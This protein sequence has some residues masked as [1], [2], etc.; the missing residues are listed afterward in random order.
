MSMLKNK[1]GLI[2]GIANEHSIAYGCAK[3]LRADGAE[4]AATYLNEEEEPYVRPL[5]EKLKCPIILPC[6]VEKP[7]ELEA[8]FD[9]IAAD[10][11]RLDFVLHSI[12]F[13]PAE[14]LHGRVVDCSRD[15][16]ILAMSIS[17]HSFIRMARLAEPLL[18]DGGCLL[19]MSYYGA[20]RVVEFYNIM[21]PVKAAL[22]TTIRYI[23]VELG[24]RGIRVNAI[25]PGPVQT[26]AASGI[27][28]F[29]RILDKAVAKSPEHRLITTDD[30]G[31]LAAFLISDQAVAITGE[32]IHV[33]AGY[34]AVD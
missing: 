8:V 18:T 32:I 34:H 6:D 4:L 19:T 11:G 10:W 28:K 24:G 3:A 26:R 20:E 9:R 33:D 27:E 12:A 22:E 17:V 15:G 25:S 16:F 29:D 31:A 5:A 23:A 14:D 1:K 2:I 13:A 30:V 21:G 7:G